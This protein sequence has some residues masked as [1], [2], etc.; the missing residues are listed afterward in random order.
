MLN[1]FSSLTRRARA[2][3]DRNAIMCSLIFSYSAPY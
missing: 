3:F 1:N 2:P